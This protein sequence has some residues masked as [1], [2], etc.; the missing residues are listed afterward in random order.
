MRIAMLWLC[1]ALAS[2][3]FA[4]MLYSVIAYRGTPARRPARALIEMLWAAVPI[5]IVVTAAMPTLRELLAPAAPLVVT[6][7]D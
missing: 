2:V 3:V 1:V 7:Q 4:F 6:I 5:V